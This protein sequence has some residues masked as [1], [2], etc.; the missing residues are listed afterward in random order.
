MNEVYQGCVGKY[1]HCCT[2]GNGLT[3][4]EF[5]TIAM[6]LR[7]VSNVILPVKMS[8]AQIPIRSTDRLYRNSI[9]LLS[10]HTFQEDNC[11][12]RLANYTPVENITDRLTRLDLVQPIIISP[13]GQM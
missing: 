8:W 10:F 2:C 12:V 13:I 3:H 6:L 7:D 1:R 9:L 4:G 11:L 5:A